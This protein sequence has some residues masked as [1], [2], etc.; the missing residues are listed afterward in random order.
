MQNELY[1]LSEKCFTD[2][3]GVKQGMFI[4]STDATN[5]VLLF[6]HGGPGMPEYFLEKKFPTGL[7]SLFTMCYWEQRGAGISYSPNMAPEGITVDQLIDDTISVTKYLCE[8]FGQQKIYLMAHS[9]G[10]Y[11]GI[12]AAEKAPELFYAYIGIGQIAQMFESER[13]AY[14]YMLEEYQKRG[15]RKMV[16]KLQSYAVLESDDVVLAFFSTLLRDQAMHKMGI[17]TMRRMTSI[18]TGVFIPVLCCRA[19]SLRE[20]I[21]IWQAKAFLRSKTGL[22]HHFFTADL[23]SKA[24]RLDMPCYFMSGR[25]DYTVNAELSKK[26]LDMIDAPKKAF[27]MFEQSAHSPMFEEPERLTEILAQD[28]MKKVAASA[29]ML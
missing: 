8:R 5:P 23:M 19:Y 2:I 4:T 11:I 16:R 27:Y 13:I 20:R 14:A 21:A 25:Y 1:S 26:L 28:I 10:S 18:I 15:D 17:G 7:E 24:I 29:N 6:V 3:N 12:Q 9:W 22:I